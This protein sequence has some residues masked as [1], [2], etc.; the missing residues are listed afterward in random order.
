MLWYDIIWEQA[1]L[2][3][4]V[5]KKKVAP[6]NELERM[7]CNALS[8]NDPL[9]KVVSLASSRNELGNSSQTPGWYK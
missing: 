7:A 1:L 9:I 2:Q 8:N 3:L 6:S 4:P 5:P